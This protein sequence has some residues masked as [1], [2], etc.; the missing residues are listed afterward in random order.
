MA[1]PKPTTT[2]TPREKPVPGK[3]RDFTQPKIGEHHLKVGIW[4]IENSGKSSFAASIC[5]L[6]KT[7]KIIY[8]YTDKSAE[9]IF[10]RFPEEVKEGRF[11]IKH[12]EN[13]EDIE[14]G[15]EDLKLLPPKVVERDILAVVL[16]TVT[17]YYDWLVVKR[18]E[19]LQEAGKTRGKSIQLIPS[20]YRMPNRW[21]RMTLNALFGLNCHTIITAKA[22][23][24]WEP[25]P[26]TRGD[27]GETIR[28][29]TGRYEPS[30]KT[31]I[32][33]YLCTEI[34]RLEPRNVG[35]TIQWWGVIT[36]Q[37]V[38]NEP[39]GIE[40]RNITAPLLVDAL[41]QLRQKITKK[42]E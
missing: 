11:F 13:I 28:R 36:K 2:V 29:P 10:D 31:D 7:G 6:K 9:P 34:V 16:D 19:E 17:D 23:E 27:A 12:C 37:K 33:N 38:T 22:R 35:G 14:M 4:G 8:F 20:D 40:V 3:F 39:A 26:G 32:L 30:W 5:K 15:I 1:Q 18:A 42:E 41:E 25:V 21:L 24:L